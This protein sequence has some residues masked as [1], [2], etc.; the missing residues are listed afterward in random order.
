MA[1]GTDMRLTTELL[2]ER[3]VV[4]ELHKILAPRTFLG[5]KRPG[6][7]PVSYGVPVDTKLLRHFADS[8]FIHH[9]Q[10]PH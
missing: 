5:R 1:V 10:S 3:L 9:T 4:M 6:G 2:T 7:N 8:K